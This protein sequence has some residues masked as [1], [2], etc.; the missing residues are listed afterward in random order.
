MVIGILYGSIIGFRGLGL[1]L[2][3][4]SP[5]M[6]NQMGTLENDLETGGCTGLAGVVTNINVR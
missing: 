6:E 2:R 1:L 4:I 3:D 5:R